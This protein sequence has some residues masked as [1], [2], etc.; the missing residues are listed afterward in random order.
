MSEDRLASGKIAYGCTSV[1]LICALG[2]ITVVLQLYLG[3]MK[4]FAHGNG[5]P[6]L[7]LLWVPFVVL[8]SGILCTSKLVAVWKFCGCPT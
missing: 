8:S 7:D 4:I 2:Q 5:K 6:T 3:S 1:N